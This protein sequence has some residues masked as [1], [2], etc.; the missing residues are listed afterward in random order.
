MAA[1]EL[2]REI[3]AR[4]DRVDGGI[5]GIEARL[6]RYH[7]ETRELVEAMLVVVRMN[8]AAFSELREAVR[9]NSDQARANTEAVLRLLDRFAGGDPPAAP[10]A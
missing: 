6:D 7:G 2:D 9:E 5:R 1:E 3:S 8:A 4:F 10:A